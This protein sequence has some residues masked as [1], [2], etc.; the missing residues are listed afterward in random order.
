MLV[1]HGTWLRA[2]SSPRGS[3]SVLEKVGIWPVS[4]PA[5]ESGGTPKKVSRARISE[6]PAKAAPG[7]IHVALGEVIALLDPPGSGH[8]VPANHYRERITIGQI[9]DV[10]GGFGRGKLLCFEC[11]DQFSGS[12]KEC[13]I[14]GIFEI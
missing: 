6:R 14:V 4:A 10:L 13:G 12:G 11:F 7:I 8:C 9:E 3:A 5:E 1:A 2:I